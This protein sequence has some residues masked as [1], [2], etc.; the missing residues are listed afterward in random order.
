MWGSNLQES[1][2]RESCVSMTEPARHPGFLIFWTIILNPIFIQNMFLS[3]PVDE[4]FILG[5]D[6]SWERSYWLTVWLDYTSCMGY[7][8]EGLWELYFFWDSS[9]THSSWMPS[10]MSSHSRYFQRPII[11]ISH[12]KNNLN[13]YYGPQLI[14][15]PKKI[16][17]L[18]NGKG[19]KAYLY[20]A[21]YNT[22]TPMS[23]RTF[24]KYCCPNI[25]EF[26]LFISHH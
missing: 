2:D 23:T 20:T 13:R 4:K 16:T 1:C 25:L 7:L 17:H 18:W 24:R 11:I 8:G 15:L 22:S 21:T 3:L 14:F 5:H 19:L 10:L 9:L 6:L 26:S 12:N